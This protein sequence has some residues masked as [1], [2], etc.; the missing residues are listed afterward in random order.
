MHFAGPGGGNDPEW[1][2][3]W[4]DPPF[5]S[6]ISGHSTFSMAAAVAMANFFGTEHV[7]FCANADPNAHDAQNRPV[8]GAAAQRCF[9]SLIDAA[10]EAGESRLI[11][12]IHFPSDNIEGLI[13]G[14]KIADQVTAN[15]F[16]PVA[17]PSAIA[18]LAAGITLF[19]GLW[20]PPHRPAAR[21]RAGLS[22][23]KRS[24]RAP[25]RGYV[26]KQRLRPRLRSNRRGPVLDE[27]GACQRGEAIAHQRGVLAD[28]M[29]SQ[30]VAHR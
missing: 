28:R 6:Y 26:D 14:E 23:G 2:P 22:G 18:V 11:N 12:G 21:E 10:H 8:M 30:R 13:T 24:A 5:Q 29:Q 17:E 9:T 1:Q 4:P 19:F 7:P 25:G 16:T 27:L 3:L 20:R 15:A